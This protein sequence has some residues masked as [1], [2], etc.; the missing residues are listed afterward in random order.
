M[1]LKPPARGNAA[2]APHFLEWVRRSLA[3]RYSTEEIW[4]KGLK[5]YTTLNIEMQNAAMRALREGLRKYD[6]ARG[7]RGPIGNILKEPARQPRDVFPPG[8]A[9]ALSIPDDIAV[10]LIEG[11]A[12]NEATVR[13]GKYRGTSAQRKLHGQRHRRRDR[14]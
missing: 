5:V 9:I 3:G 4:R 1:I 12:G 6:K 14:S 11:V 8:L 7:W 13:I 2:I 10:G